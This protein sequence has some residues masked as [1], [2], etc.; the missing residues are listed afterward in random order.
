MSEMSYF[1]HSEKHGT[2]NVPNR[3]LRDNGTEVF[4][5]HKIGTVPEKTVQMWYLLL[6]LPG[7]ELGLL[8]LQTAVNTIG[9]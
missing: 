1:H 3:I 6:P 2:F 7:I 5:T 9:L 4:N 8:Q